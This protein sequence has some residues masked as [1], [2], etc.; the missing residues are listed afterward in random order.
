[1]ENSIHDYIKKHNLDASGFTKEIFIRALCLISKD[2]N[3]IGLVIKDI[4]LVY[5]NY[6]LKFNNNA[7]PLHNYLLSKLVYM[8]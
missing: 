7:T 4:E 3:D 1:M 5:A 8:P 2:N 6:Q